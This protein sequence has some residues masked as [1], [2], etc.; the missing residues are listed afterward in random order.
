MGHFD[1][2]YGKKSPK[3]ELRVH[4]KK[5]GQRDGTTGPFFY[6]QTERQRLE[7]MKELGKKDT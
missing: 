4:E 6:L 3:F 1:S 7:T 5:R 2:I